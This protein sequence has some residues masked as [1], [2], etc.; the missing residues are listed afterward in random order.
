MMVGYHKH[1][2]Y[3]EDEVSKCVFINIQWLALNIS[4]SLLLAQFVFIFEIV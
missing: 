4:W 1:R 2:N 3:L